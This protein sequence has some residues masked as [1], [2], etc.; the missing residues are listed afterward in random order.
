MLSNTWW[1]SNLTLPASIHRSRIAS[2]Q[3]L[4]VIPGDFDMKT[5]IRVIPRASPR[6]TPHVY[7]PMTNNTAA[8][9]VLGP[10]GSRH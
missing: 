3:L 7:A 2:Y 1:G 5:V 10:P 8:I 9:E 4:K 6:P